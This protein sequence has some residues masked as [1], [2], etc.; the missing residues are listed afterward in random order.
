MEPPDKGETSRHLELSESKKNAL[1]VT[2]INTVK[3]S[4]A[5]STNNFY[6]AYPTIGGKPQKSNFRTESKE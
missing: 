4:A 3:Y 6:N 5:F 2:N 1:P